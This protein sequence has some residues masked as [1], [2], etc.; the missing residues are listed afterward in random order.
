VLA[1]DIA[2]LFVSG[3]PRFKNA[4]HGVDYIVGEIDWLGFLAGALTL[5]ALT[6]VAV[7]RLLARRRAHGARA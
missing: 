6:A 3:I 2:A 7:S 4:H 1:L 5:L